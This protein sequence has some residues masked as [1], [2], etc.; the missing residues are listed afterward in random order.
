MRERPA[1][2]D[3]SHNIL[4]GGEGT[5]ADV[6]ASKLLGSRNNDT[7]IRQCLKRV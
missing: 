2:H 4:E 6:T 3:C 5:G 7:Q 1:C